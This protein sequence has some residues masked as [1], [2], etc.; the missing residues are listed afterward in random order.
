MQARKNWTQYTHHELD[1]AFGL[2]MLSQAPVVFANNPSQLESSQETRSDDEAP[3][4]S[5]QYKRRNKTKNAGQ[6][7]FEF[8]KPGVRPPSKKAQKLIKNQDETQQPNTDPIEVKEY[9]APNQTKKNGKES[10]VIIKPTAE[11]VR[12]HGSKPVVLK[13]RNSL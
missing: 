11:Q 6:K 10:F 7:L 8:I 13:I 5:K 3:S 1:A 4:T 9:N 12:N 2:I